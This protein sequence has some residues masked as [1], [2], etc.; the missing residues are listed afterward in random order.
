[1]PFDPNFP[2]DP[3]DPSQWWQLRNLLQPSAQPTAPP[4]AAS[5]TAAQSSRID[6]PE[7]DGLPN[8]WFVPEADG[9]PN[10]WFVPDADGYAPTPAAAP[11]TAPSAPSP[12]TNVVNP[13]TSNRPPARFDPLAAYWAQVP[14]SRVG[15]MA[16][17][18]PIFLSPDS[19][20]PQETPSSARGGPPAAFSNP[21]A[22]FLPAA[23]TLP[24]LPPDFGTGGILGGIAKLAAA[25][26]SSDPVSLVASRGLF[27]SSANPQP[28]ASNAQP[29]PPSLPISRRLLPPDPIGYQGPKNLYSHVGNDPLIRGD[30]KGFAA[31]QSGADGTPGSAPYQNSAN[32][33]FLLIS[34][35]KPSDHGKPDPAV[36]GGLVPGPLWTSPNGDLPVQIP[37]P[38]FLPESDT[39]SRGGAGSTPQ[40]GSSPAPTVEGGRTSISS[41]P[42][43]AK[44][45]EQIRDAL[46]QGPEGLQ[47]VISAGLPKYDNETTYGV[48]ITN[49][50]EIVPLKSGNPSSFYENYTSA[51]H[52]EG[53]GAIWIREHGS[54]AGVLYH[55][56][57]GGICGYCD[58]HIETLLPKD[59][60]LLVIPPADAVAKKQGAV[61]DPTAYKGNSEMPKLPRQY[62]LF[63]NQP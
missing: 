52:V 51:G 56:N 60:E 42:D 57:T 61:V 24:T 34:G 44:L 4:N 54:T 58:D 55:N 41:E 9:Y 5:G 39:G 48:L 50:G 32:P 20:A 47:A 30:T 10:D 6:V 28:T 14:A 11:R 19:F 35:D 27:G 37:F 29:A 22:Q 53:K 43:W 45:T 2:F 16:W 18:P 7:A 25:Y 23:S 21:L 46:S 26:A 17:H 49:E 15:A 33:N 12:Q 62:D 8:D 3:A 40:G 13:A 36:L 59:A 38:W 63:R 31:D 1:M